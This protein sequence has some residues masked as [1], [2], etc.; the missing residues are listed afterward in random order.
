MVWTGD[1]TATSIS[2]AVRAGTSTATEAATEALARIADRDPMLRT[3]VVVRTHAA[4]AEAAAIDNRP[5][6]LMVRGR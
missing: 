2:S 5:P 4:L 3:F 1:F 6:E